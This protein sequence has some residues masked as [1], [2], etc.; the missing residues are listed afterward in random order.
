ML[1]F[2]KQKFLILIKSN[3]SF[4]MHGTL[5]DLAQDNNAW[6][7]KIVFYIFFQKILFLGPWSI[8]S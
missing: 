5:G 1:S 6:D 2:K 8:L 3:L 4:L 7:Q